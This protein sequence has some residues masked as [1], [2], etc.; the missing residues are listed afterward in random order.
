MENHE[1][2]IIQSLYDITCFFP[3]A[4]VVISDLAN[5]VYCMKCANVITH[6]SFKSESDI[7]LPPT[8]LNICRICES[9]WPK[10][11]TKEEQINYIKKCINY[12][13]TKREELWNLVDKTKENSNYEIWIKEWN[14]EALTTSLLRISKLV[15]KLTFQLRSLTGNLPPA[16]ENDLRRTIDEAKMVSIEYIVKQLP[17]SPHIKL[18]CILCPFHNDTSPSCRLYEHN[19]HCFACGAHGDIIDLTMKLQNI[20]FKQAVLLIRN[21]F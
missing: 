11:L 9:R 17:S 21:Y 10:T 4:C 13:E 20:D 2:P 16:R 18:H 8:G 6:S 14:L 12:L 1:T 7:E 5:R 19:Y 15:D 3:E